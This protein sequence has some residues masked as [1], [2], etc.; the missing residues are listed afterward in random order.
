M[1][2]ESTN[3][4][5]AYTANPY[6]PVGTVLGPGS[7]EVRLT[8]REHQIATLVS[9]GY[10]YKR[11]SGELGITSTSIAQRL[12]QLAARIPGQGNP[13][14]K[15]AAWMWVYGSRTPS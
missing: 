10:S 1:T 9:L 14:Q 11:I 3:G 13:R 2:D 5:V 8:E 12:H 4:E 15:V 6:H 7:T